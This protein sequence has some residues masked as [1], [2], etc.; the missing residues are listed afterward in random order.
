[1]AHG[2]RFP[3]GAADRAGRSGLRGASRSRRSGG[4]V[5]GADVVPARARPPACADHRVRR[6]PAPGAGVHSVSRR[7]GPAHLGRHRLDPV[8]PAPA[9]G[10][11][12][13]STREWNTLVQPETL[14]AALG[15]PGLVVVDCRF[16]LADPAA[17]E[18]EYGRARI[19]G[20]RYAHLDRD[21]SGPHG[22]GCGRHPW[23]DAEAFTGRLSAWGISPRTRVVAYDAGDGAFAAR[24]W[25]LLR[26]LGHE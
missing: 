10:G 21:L 8:Q 1:G 4:G 23:P 14:A 25:C 24:L 20:A 16:S 19:P 12:A 11:H 2:H 17:G 7:P 15:A 22:P 18:R 5:R 13:M 26:M 3:C 9:A 6:A